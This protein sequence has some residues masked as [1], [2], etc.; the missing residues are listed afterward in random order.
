[1]ASSVDD[2]SSAPVQGNQVHRM[3][4][5][6]T[7][8]LEFSSTSVMQRARRILA[9]VGL[10]VAAM[11]DGVEMKRCLSVGGDMEPSQLHERV[12]GVLR[13]ERIRFW[14]RGHESCSAACASCNRGGASRPGS[15]R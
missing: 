6:C 15:D 5:H 9:R 10:D 3:T 4:L 11:A 14:W 8:R 13:L 12:S 1:M 7:R 2:H